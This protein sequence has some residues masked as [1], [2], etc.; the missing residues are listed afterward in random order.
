MSTDATRIGLL[1]HGETT[2]QGFCGRGSD[3]PL[4]AAGWHAMRET[5]ARDADWDRVVCSPLMRCLGPAEAFAEQ[6]GVPLAVD[7]RLAELD[8]GDWEGRTAAALMETQA[9]ALGRF[10]EDP[11]N[12]APPNGESLRAF[13]ERV[14]AGWNDLAPNEGEQVLVIAHGGVI[15]LIRALHEGWPLEKLL[16]IDVPLASLHIVEPWQVY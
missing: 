14:V 3:V 5:L 4:T 12:H 16:T 1:R 7:E 9:N 8:F 2:G 11:L 6:A 13:R 10:W 15:R